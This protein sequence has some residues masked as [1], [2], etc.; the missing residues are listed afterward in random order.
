M[1]GKL[2]EA[3]RKQVLIYD[4]S[5]NYLYPIEMGTKRKRLFLPRRLESQV[6]I[7]SNGIIL[8]DV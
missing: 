1:E 5:S 7:V 3:V 6:D 8:N 4:S 2:I